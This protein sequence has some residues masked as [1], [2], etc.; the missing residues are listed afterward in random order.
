MRS[1]SSAERR[2][3]A[4]ALVGALVLGGCA[5][6]APALP[7]VLSGR[8]SLEEFAGADKALDCGAIAAERGV[9]AERRVAANGRIAANRQ[10]NQVAGYFAA[11]ILPPLWLA[12]EGNH[13]D[14]EE[15]TA[16]QA[17]QDTL[18]RLAAAKECPSG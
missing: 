4:A 9:I 11:V 17:R 5:A 8:P 10:Q 16:L 7:P 12:T 13:A 6:S 1:P 18:L 15:L 14:K 2:N 3:H